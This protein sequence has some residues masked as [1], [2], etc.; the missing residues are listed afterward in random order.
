VASLVDGS[1]MSL[2]GVTPALVLGVDGSPS[3][4]ACAGKGSLLDSK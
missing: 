1:R 4:T 3:A 2:S